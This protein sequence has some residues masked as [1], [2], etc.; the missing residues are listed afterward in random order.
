MIYGSFDYD[1]VMRYP[2]L[3]LKMT[4][5]AL[6]VIKR[7]KNELNKRITVKFNSQENSNLYNRLCSVSSASK[8]SKDAVLKDYNITLYLSDSNLPS[9]NDFKA[10]KKLY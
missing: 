10:I 1:F 3:R 2:R 6:K 8:L 4:N 5:E 7:D 9:Y